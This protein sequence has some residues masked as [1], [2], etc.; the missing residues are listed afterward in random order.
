[1]SFYVG[2][3]EGA[4]RSCYFEDAVYKIGKYSVS[5]PDYAN[6]YVSMGL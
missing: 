3:D 6:N 5:C 4:L 1:M 2:W